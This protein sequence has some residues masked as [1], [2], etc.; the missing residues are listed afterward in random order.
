MEAAR[1]LLHQWNRRKVDG[2][3]RVGGLLVDLDAVE[4]WLLGQQPASL[5]EAERLLDLIAA[6][7]AGLDGDLTGLCRVGGAVRND[8]SRH[9]SRVDVSFAPCASGPMAGRA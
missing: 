8:V 1:A 6:H 2:A 9:R 7:E 3:V 4:T 5:V